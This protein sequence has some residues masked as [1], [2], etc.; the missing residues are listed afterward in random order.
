[1][2][3]LL[4]AAALLLV[5]CPKPAPVTPS[6]IYAEL[7]EAGCLASDDA[8]LAAVQQESQLDA[9]PAWFLCLQSGGTVTGCDVPCEAGVSP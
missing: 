7:V 8:G 4:I 6:S 5:A 3:R 9:A 1:M 2:A